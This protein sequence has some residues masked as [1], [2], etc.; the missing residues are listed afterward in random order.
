M[1]FLHNRLMLALADTPGFLHLLGA[2]SDFK[3]RDE[4][5]GSKTRRQAPP[6]YI[7]AL[8]KAIRERRKKLGLLQKHVAKEANMQ[9]SYFCEIERGGRNPTIS[10]IYSIALSLELTPR[11]LMG[12]AEAIFIESMR[13]GKESAI[14]N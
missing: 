14:D 4:M 5:K 11:Q 2:Q 1:T 12:I 6:L 13:S 7:K 8:G 3:T 9:V 10:V